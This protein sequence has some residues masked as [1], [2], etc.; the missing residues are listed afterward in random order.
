MIDPGTLNEPGALSE[1][2]ALNKPAFHAE[3]LCKRFGGRH[4]LGGPH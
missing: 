2:S 1:A 3:G 4:A